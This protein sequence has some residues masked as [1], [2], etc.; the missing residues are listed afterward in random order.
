[1]LPV[2][3]HNTNI[4]S[5]AGTFF[6]L[7]GEDFHFQLSADETGLYLERNGEQCILTPDMLTSR[8]R[9]FFIMTWSPT[10]LRLV[11][12]EPKGNQ[13]LLL[14]LLRLLLNIT[15]KQILN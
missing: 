14:F 7:K 11:T 5:Q 3:N 2:N 6:N 1:M 8:R 4:F 9:R 10:T 13:N 12:P 15:Y